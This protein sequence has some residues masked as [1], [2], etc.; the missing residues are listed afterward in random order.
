MVHVE[1]QVSA[2]TGS[3]VASSLVGGSTPQPSRLLSELV[4]S[5]S[6]TQAEQELEALTRCGMWSV[7][8]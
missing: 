5:P 4:M 7:A 8:I 6:E 3:E 1:T 2:L